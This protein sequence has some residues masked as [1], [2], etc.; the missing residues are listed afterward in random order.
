[1]DKITFTRLGRGYY[2]I[3]VDGIHRPVLIVKSG[4]SWIVQSANQN[5]TATTEQVQ[6]RAPRLSDAKSLAIATW[7]AIDSQRHLDHYDALTTE[8]VQLNQLAR[9]YKITYPILPDETTLV[10]HV[11]YVR[12]L[13]NRKLYNL[14]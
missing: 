11:Q 6:G 7:Y 2:T 5:R 9:M 1:M 13:I 14:K 8:L 12:R 4:R 10:E 3:T